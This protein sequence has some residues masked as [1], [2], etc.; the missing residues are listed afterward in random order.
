MASMGLAMVPGCVPQSS[1][2][3]CRLSGSMQVSQCMEVRCVHLEH[4]T[5][6]S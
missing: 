6:Q 5:V 3:H 2:C 4:M 1:G